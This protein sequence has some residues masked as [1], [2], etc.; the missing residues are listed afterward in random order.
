[1][2]EVG[3]K[4]NLIQLGQCVHMGEIAFAKVHPV[5]VCKWQDPFKI[6]ICMILELAVLLPLVMGDTAED[7]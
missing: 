6:S 3:L 2:K 5:H 4:I 7:G 1:M